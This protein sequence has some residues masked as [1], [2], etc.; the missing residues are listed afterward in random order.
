MDGSRRAIIIPA[1]ANAFA[2]ALRSRLETSAATATNPTQSPRDEM[3]IA[4]ISRANVRWRNRSRRVAGLVPRSWAMSSATVATKRQPTCTKRRQA[5]GVR[6]EARKPG[7]GG[8]G[9]GRPS[10]MQKRR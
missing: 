5:S 9:R 10:P 7:G 8:L 4:A 1:T 2:D 3:V 6:R